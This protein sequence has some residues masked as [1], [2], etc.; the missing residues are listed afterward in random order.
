MHA[1]VYPFKLTLFPIPDVRRVTAK[2]YPPP[3]PVPA[4]D[5]MPPVDPALPSLDIESIAW[6][7][8]KEQGAASDQ[9]KFKVGIRARRIFGRKGASPH[10]CE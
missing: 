10:P 5:S 7:H 6:F 9:L 3:L 4:P 2:T 1:P 8:N